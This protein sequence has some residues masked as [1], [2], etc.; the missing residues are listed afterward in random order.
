MNILVTG[1]TGF[2]GRE[3]LL[4]LASAGH[5]ITILT[6]DEKTAPVKVPVHCRIFRWDSSLLQPPKEAFDGIDAV[7][8]LAGENIVGRWTQ[9]RKTEIKRSRVLSTH[10]LVEAFRQLDKKPEVFICASGI[11]IYGDRQAVELDDSASPGD[12]FLSELCQSWESEALKAE[13]LGIRTV[14]LR[15]GV[16]LGRRGGAFKLM[17]PSFRLGL[18]G[19]I[20]NGE[21]WMSWI[22]VNDLA[23]MVLHLLEQKSVTGPV[24][25]VSSQPIQNR[26]FSKLLG[27]VLRRPALLPAPRFLIK[28]LLGE[29]AEIMLGSLKVLPKKIEQSGFE[30]EFP[31]PETALSDLCQ[32]VTQEFRMEMWVPKTPQQAFDFFADA[33]NLERIHPPDISFQ[34]VRMSTSTMG[35]GTRGDYRLKIRGIPIRWQSLITDW[36]PPHRF[37]DFQVIGPYWMWYHT[38]EFME[39][40][41]GTLIIDRAVYRIPFWVFGDVL[42]AG[43]IK[44]DLEKI[45]LYRRERVAEMM[46]R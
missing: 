34:I 28:L 4:K 38:H 32:E 46:K 2:I 45:F 9:T 37:S 14:A 7:V 17:S 5:E 25:A 40:D 20:G 23:R 44:N 41:G 3:V 42:G 12:G 29:T 18:G 24:N 22:H 13:T 27:K 21:Q 6:R 31:D 43:W 1:A 36:R 35:E 39:K 26:T 10:H 15:I 19:R 16:V 30:F 8:H 11:G 33:E